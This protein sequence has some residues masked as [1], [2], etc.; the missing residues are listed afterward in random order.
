MGTFA[1]TEI[2]NYHFFADQGKQT[3]VFR[4]RLQLTNLSCLFPFSVSRKQMEVVLSQYV[5]PFAETLQH[6]HEDMET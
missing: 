5:V 3:S 4:F 2:V 1:E 6:G